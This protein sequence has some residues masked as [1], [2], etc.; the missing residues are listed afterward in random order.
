MAAG[1]ENFIF[2]LCPLDGVRFILPTRIF[3][4]NLKL[5]IQHL[6]IILQFAGICQHKMPRLNF[7]KFR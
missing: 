4:R 5:D 1:R 3:Y 6:L 2:F 7:S